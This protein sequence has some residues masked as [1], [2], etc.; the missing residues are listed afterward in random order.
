MFQSF[1]RSF[2]PLV[3]FLATLCNVGIFVEA[4]VDFCGRPGA[5][6][7]MDR[8]DCLI[9]VNPNLTC[10]Q[11]WMQLLQ[12][13]YPDPYTNQMVNLFSNNCCNSGVQAYC[14][15]NPFAEPAQPAQ[16]VRGPEP[17]CNICNGNGEKSPTNYNI[18]LSIR[19]L[20]TN[21]SCE[22]LEGMGLDGHVPS[23][24]CG[25][26]AWRIDDICGCQYYVTQT[27]SYQQAIPATKQTTTSTSKTTSSDCTNY[28][29]KTT[30]K[31]N[32][33]KWNKK[34]TKCHNY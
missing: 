14:L 33:C 25:A 27:R 19:Y 29:E 15:S 28:T 9:H 18:R 32:N 5:L 16:P 26:I 13:P 11:L 3:L 2:A 24:L 23:W 17:T 21:L 12:I 7:P 6:P 10:G 22:H 20:G 34:Y 1:A 8:F 4:G 31:Q 30:C